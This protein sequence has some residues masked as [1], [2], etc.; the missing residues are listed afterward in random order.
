MSDEITPQYPALLP[1]VQD[2]VAERLNQDPQLSSQCVTFLPEH[3]LEIDYEI[4]SA[5]GKQGIV[6]MVNV[7]KAQ[8]GGH[9]GTSTAWEMQVEIDVVENPQVRRAQMKK[10]GI[11]HGTVSDIIGYVQESLC[12]PISPTYGMFC[13]VSNEVGEDSGFM[14]GKAVMKTYAVG[15]ISGIVSGE[16]HWEVPFALQSDLSALSAQVQEISAEI[17]GMTDDYVPLVLDGDTNI[18]T[19]GHT[20]TIGAN[21]EV[22]GSIVPFEVNAQ[23]MVSA[24]YLYGRVFGAN[25]IEVNNNTEAVGLSAFN[26]IFHT[27]GGQNW[28]LGN[29]I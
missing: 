11:Q 28:Y 8:Y 25:Q 19:N 18:D 29:T 1:Q 6:G 21:P 12:A 24:Y 15:E 10:L 17:S 13:P 26:N 4:K 23:G 3:K 14:V 2:F 27:G 20:F 22:P 7:P 16:T 5:L 9:D